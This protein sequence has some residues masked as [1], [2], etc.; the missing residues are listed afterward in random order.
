MFCVVSVFLL[1]LRESST[2]CY[3]VTFYEVR[4]G[5]CGLYLLTCCIMQKLYIL[6]HLRLRVTLLQNLR[7]TTSGLY[8]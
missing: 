8:N 2:F 5:F 6:T 4:A 3:D 1:S 7:R